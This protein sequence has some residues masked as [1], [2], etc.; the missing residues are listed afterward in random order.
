MQSYRARAEGRRLITPGAAAPSLETT[1]LSQDAVSLAPRRPL[2]RA[3]WWIPL[4]A[5][6]TGIAIWGL[7]YPD[8]TAPAP[9][10]P[11]PATLRAE[12]QPEGPALFYAVH[13]DRRFRI[14]TVH[15]RTP[16]RGCVARAPGLAIR[17]DAN[18]QPWLITSVAAEA[19]LSIKQGHRR[20]R[21]VTGLLSRPMDAQTIARLSAPLAQ[22]QVE[23]G[24]SLVATTPTEGL[25]EVISYLAWLKSDTGRALRDARLWPG[26]APLDPTTLSPAVRNRLT[27]ERRA[28]E[29]QTDRSTPPTAQGQRHILAPTGPVFFS[30]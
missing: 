6:A 23:E 2:P 7:L 22:L 4:G 17:L 9:P 24:G 16:L 13:D 15:C 27:A 20:P 25:D 1:S 8:S 12:I 14:W 10:A 30:P 11:P 18:H 5:L 3:I 28:L 26:K 21:R 29:A 19:Q